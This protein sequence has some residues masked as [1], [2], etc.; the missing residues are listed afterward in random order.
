MARRRTGDAPG[1]GSGH[2]R[3]KGISFLEE[4]RGSAE[5]RGHHDRGRVSQ[6]AQ[7]WKLGKAAKQERSKLR[8]GAPPIR[9]PLGAGRVPTSQHL[10]SAPVPALLWSHWL[11]L[12]PRPRKICFSQPIGRRGGGGA[13]ERGTR[14]WS[15]GCGVD[16]GGPRFVELFAAVGSGV[17]CHS[18]AGACA[19]GGLVPACGGGKM[20]APWKVGA[21]PV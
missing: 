3:V 16:L 12:S 14:T 5:S 9:P 15:R 18:R 4:E 6:Q 1:H 13:W 21:R 2:T 11:T 7:K 10:P 8:A 17:G 20:C 19:H